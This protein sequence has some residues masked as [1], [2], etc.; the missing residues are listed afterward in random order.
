MVEQGESLVDTNDAAKFLG[1]SPTTLAIWR[2]RNRP[3]QPPYIKVGRA[4]RY[5]MESLR[6]YAEQ[7]EQTGTT[8]AKKARR[9]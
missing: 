2:W 8:V 7:R 5:R 9:K 1:I 4:V 6:A 3:G